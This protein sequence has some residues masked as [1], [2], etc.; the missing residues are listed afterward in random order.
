MRISTRYA[1]L[2]GKVCAWLRVPE[3]QS[4]TI[5]GMYLIDSHPKGST[6]GGAKWREADLEWLG[7]KPG[8]VQ[9]SVFEMGQEQPRAQEHDLQV[10]RG[11]GCYRCLLR[12]ACQ[13][14]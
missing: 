4:G 12:Q 1:Y 13:Q 14:G 6:R 2:G 8:G 5:A 7:A 11:E 3:P 9:T 10:R